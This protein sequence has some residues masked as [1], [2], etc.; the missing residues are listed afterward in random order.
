M[1]KRIVTVFI[2]GGGP[3]NPDLTSMRRRLLDEVDVVLHDRLIDL[4]LLEE[5][6]PAGEIISV[7]KRQDQIAG[8]LVIAAQTL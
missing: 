3:E 8:I 4:H 1:L 2:G 7:G 5:T 6:K